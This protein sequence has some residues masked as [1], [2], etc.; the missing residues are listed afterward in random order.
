MQLQDDT[1]YESEGRKR[2]WESV[3]EQQIR[4]DAAALRRQRN[5]GKPQPIPNYQTPRSNMRLGSSFLSLKRDG[6]P[7]DPAVAVRMAEQAALMRKVR[8]NPTD[9]VKKALAEREA[10]RQGA[11]ATAA[12]YELPDDMADRMLYDEVDKEYHDEIAGEETAPDDFPKRWAIDLC[13]FFR[14]ER[15][16][17]LHVVFIQAK[18]I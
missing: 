18:A 16:L 2:R 4:E 9:S 7:E 15:A 3:E 14:T 10:T 17:N 13:N 6:N 12:G 5:K 1:Y 11:G 8:G